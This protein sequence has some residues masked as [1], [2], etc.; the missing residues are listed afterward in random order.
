ME[1]DDDEGGGG[2]GVLHIRVIPTL[3]RTQSGRIFA[4]LGKLPGTN[5]PQKPQV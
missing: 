2:G 5:A 1:Y 3:E 4:L